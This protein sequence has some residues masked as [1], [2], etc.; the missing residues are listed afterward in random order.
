M[1]VKKEGRKTI[2]ICG[3][4]KKETKPKETP[5]AETKKIESTQEVDNG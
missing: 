4:P 2:Y 5:K 1:E 3:K